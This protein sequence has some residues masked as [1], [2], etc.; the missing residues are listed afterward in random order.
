MRRMALARTQ[1]VRSGDADIA[2]RV[3][4]VGP[5]DV[6]LV[7]DWGSHLEAVAEQPFLD[8]FLQALARFSRVLWFDM[9]GIGM[10][11]SVV[12][13]VIPVESWVDDLEAVMDA[14]GSNEATIVAQGQA[15][16]MAI[17]AAATHPERVSSL[18]LVN[19]FARLARADDYP[20]GMPPHVQEV[21][22]K[23]IEL[24]W[25]TGAFATLLGPSVAHRPGVVEWWGRVER[26][27]A[28]PGL[29]RARFDSILELD[30]RDVLPLVDVPTLVVHNRDNGLVRVGHGRYLAEHIR[31]ASLLERDSADHWPLPEADLVGAIEEFVTGSR[32]KAH[33]VDRFLATVLF[34]DVVGS[35]EQLTEVGD[36]S[37]RVVLDR[38]E[39]AT[40]RVLAL[41]EGDLRDRAGDGIL[42]TFDGPVRAIRCAWHIRDDV[43]RLGLE[44]R[45]GLHCGE[46]SR[47]PDSIAGIT[48]H[49]GARVAAL[50]APS[51][52]LVT[53]TVR[54][55]VAGSGIA[56]EERGEHE[57][58]GVPERWALYAALG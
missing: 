55:L 36:R 13:G 4:G 50:A 38:F 24:Q 8:E 2:Y 34:V 47:R 30:V 39:E 25:G 29:A 44:I 14:V 37:W 21:Y 3:T 40:R 23:Q 43:R 53:R 11:R 58:K 6:V 5:P 45:A 52:V 33:D 48:V 16:Q 26:Y 41:Y 1:Y 46:V 56:F 35:T 27:G 10:S 51:E 20:A 54:D 15:V 7:Y 22:G 42:A 28:T 12:G 18:V 57:L 31:G 9:R 19:G 49:I 32:S 17:V